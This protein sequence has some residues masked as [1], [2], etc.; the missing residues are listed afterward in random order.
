MP[1]DRDAAAHADE[2]GSPVSVQHGLV[3]LEE[4]RPA[5]LHL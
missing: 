1:D 4:A 5:E 2:A 3:G